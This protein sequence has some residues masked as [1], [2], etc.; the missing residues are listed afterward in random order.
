[1]STSQ[2][3]ALLAGATV[4]L[5]SLS[6]HDVY[7]GAGWFPEVAGSVVVV[8]AAGVLGRRLGIPSLLQP[9]IAATAIIGYLLLL[10][11]RPT[12]AGGGTPTADSFSTLRAMAGQALLDAQ[13]YA[14]PV[15]ATAELVLLGVLGVSTVATLVD[16]FAV[17]LRR[18]ALAG[19]PLLALVGVASGT[20]ATGVGWWP[21]ALAASGWLALLAADASE[22]RRTWTGPLDRSQLI[23][24]RPTKDPVLNRAG[25]RIGLA[26]VGMALVLPTLVPGLDGRLLGGDKGLGAGGARAVT[27]NPLTELAGQLRLPEPRPVLTYRTTDPE[28]D[29]LRLTTL[30]VFDDETG[31][32]S[33]ELK[34]DPDA[35]RVSR[36]IELPPARRRAG[37]NSFTTSIRIQE[38]SG[39]WLPVPMTPTVIDLDGPWLWDRGSETA[40]STRSSVDDIEQDYDVTATRGAPDPAAL[41]RSGTRPPDVAALSVPP[42][43]SPYVRQITEQVVADAGNAYDEVVALQTFFRDTRNGFVYSEDADLEEVDA[44]NALERFLRGRQGFCQQYASA[45]AAMARLRGIPARV[46]VGFTAGTRSEDGR[47]QVTTNDAHA[48]PE[49]WFPAGGWVR[50]EPTPR[51]EQVS[52]PGYSTPAPEEVPAG[53]GPLPTGLPAPVPGS[54]AE[55]PQSQTESQ[56]RAAD[57][58][59]EDRGISAGRVWPALVAVAVLAAAAAPSAAAAVRRRRRWRAPDPAIAWEQLREDAV[60]LGHQWRPADS[61]RTAAARL[62]VERVLPQEAAQ[63]ARRLASAVEVV[64]YGRPTAT[65]PAGG[66]LRRDA[67]VLRAALLA[68]SPRGVRI[69]ARLLPASATRATAAAVMDTF[70][71]LRGQPRVW[72]TRDVRVRQADQ[73]RQAPGT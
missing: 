20:V 72:L 30:D 43:V 58:P 50:F 55:R 59:A 10:Y 44:P 12:L 70:G 57:Q 39:P 15:P 67:S 25:R 46:G 38:L 24:G 3:S 63:A 66:D 13:E 17:G 18:P 52:T 7:E 34:A 64:R 37:G 11:A 19:V 9:V 6:L 42:N 45:M 32:S 33:S 60:D 23:R 14:A 22:Q 56:G 53:E 47:Y 51:R 40:F 1:M 26:A 28:P 54:A 31:W 49:V 41:R 73:C 61:P 65:A 71:R 8:T 36:G 2:P 29:Y 16:L 5:T 4:L 68:S 48:W 27:Y 21:L 69:R 35:D 62:V